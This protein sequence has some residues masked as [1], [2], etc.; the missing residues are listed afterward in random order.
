VLRIDV[1][2]HLWSEPLVEALARRKKPP[3]IRRDGRVWALTVNGEASS[4]IDVVGD[5]V[6]TR[7]ALVHLDGLDV[8]VLSLS[9]VLGVEA[10]PGDEAGDV[11]EAY[12]SG[13]EELPNTFGAWASLP[14]REAT[15]ADAEDA[16]DRFYAGLC[17]PAGAIATPD[18]LERI[19][20]ILAAAE[21]RAA[22]VFVHP[23]PDPFAPGS[24]AA[25]GPSWFPALTTYIAS[26][27]AAWHAFAAIGRKLLPHLRV[28]FAMLAGG[29]PFHL[30][31]LV[32]R[33]GSANRAFDRN[34][35]Y[36]TSSYGGRAIDGMVRAVGIDQ[37]LHGSD[38]PVVAP[39]PPPGPLGDAAWAAM[40][41][42]NP[43]RLFATRPESAVVA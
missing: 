32:A 20:P 4:T 3:F 43:A 15:D 36:E 30:E 11:I 17:I 2:Q 24:S 22:P 8:A 39:P 14:L 12:E 9:A 26:M 41:R 5:D 37:L 6:A 38:R 42:A 28:V 21:R 35:Y 18:R 10:L 1:H 33:G 23:G 34:L 16:L 27:N 19:A 13:I 7:G 40:T 25:A 31:R 29:A